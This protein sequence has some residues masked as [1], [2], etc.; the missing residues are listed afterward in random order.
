MQRFFQCAIHIVVVVNLYGRKQARQS[1]TGLHG[2][3]DGNVVP[4]TATEWG[5]FTTVQIGGD[6]GEP[7]FQLAEIVGPA[8][9]GKQFLQLD[10][11]LF[12]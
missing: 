7:V 11:D 9:S 2:A 6:Q 1:R 10:V 3:R 8:A 12:I 4:A 5:C